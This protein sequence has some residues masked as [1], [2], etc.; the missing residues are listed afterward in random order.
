MADLPY[1]EN[2]NFVGGNFLPVAVLFNEKYREMN[3]AAKP[4]LFKF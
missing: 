2:L 3:E 4:T 1:G